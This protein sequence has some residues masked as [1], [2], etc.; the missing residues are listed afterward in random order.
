MKPYLVHLLL[1]GSWMLNLSASETLKVVTTTPDFAA[2]ARVIGGDRAEV[3]SLAKP[4]EDPHFVDPKPSL[5]LK[6]N[7]ADILI[8]SG[9]ELEVGWLPALLQRVRNPRILPGAPGRVLA[10]EVVELLEVPTS[11]DRS[12]G[13]IHAL[14]NPHFMTDPDNALKVARRIAEVL[15]RLDTG[16]NRL[17][18]DNLKAFSDLVETKLAE[19]Q[20]LLSPFKDQHICAYHN[21]WPYF[22]RRFGIKIDLFLEPKPGLP[23]TPAHLADVIAKMKQFGVRVIIV[24]PYLDRRTA[25]SVARQTGA[26]VI[27]A[28]TYPGGV[29]GTEG[30]YVKL[31]DYLVRSLVRALGGETQPS[32]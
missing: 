7:N 8:E 28:P 3:V 4:T 20:R 22:A 15:S 10:S 2:I 13:D 24:Q 27:D 25:E 5:I 29:R 12:K 9:A 30:D 31:M 16:P 26:V 21:S 32:R 14:G 18:H 17:Y 23:P 6:L 1:V 11:L 19:W